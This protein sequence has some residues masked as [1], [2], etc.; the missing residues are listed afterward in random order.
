MQ[1]IAFDIEES[2][3]LNGDSGPY[4]LY[5]YARC[6]SVLRK[7]DNI[8]S[9]SDSDNKLEESKSFLKGKPS[10]GSGK[11]Y[12]EEVITVLRLIYRFPEVVS[13]AAETYSPNTLCKYLYDLAGA[14]NTFYN[15]HSILSR[16]YD[17][18]DE[19]PVSSDQLNE[20][21]DT[22][23]VIQ[24][25]LALTSATAQILHDGLHFLGIKTLERM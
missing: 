1:E 3:N 13:E 7:A 9:L 6:K 24:F 22:Q 16:T 2:V 10:T 25:R 17:A 15:K 21:D 23:D 11:N 4:L 12:N 19:K 5:T 20:N 8:S 18:G 14:F